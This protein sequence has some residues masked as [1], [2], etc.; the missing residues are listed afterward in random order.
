MMIKLPK[1]FNYVAGID[2]KFVKNDRLSFLQLR[3]ETK[4]YEIAV[5]KLSF[6]KLDQL[7]S[8]VHAMFQSWIGQRDGAWFLTWTYER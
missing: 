2:R 6:M 8:C 4:L 1:D 3:L 7:S 5:Q